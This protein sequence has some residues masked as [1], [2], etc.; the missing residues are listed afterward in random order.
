LP[1]LN[2]YVISVT[3]ACHCILPLNLAFISLAKLE[4]HFMSPSFVFHLML[5]PLGWLYFVIVYFVVLYYYLRSY[6]YPLIE[7]LRPLSS[8]FDVIFPLKCSSYLLQHLSHSFECCCCHSKFL[9]ATG[10]FHQPHHPL[11]GPNIYCCKLLP[12]RLKVC[13]MYLSGRQ[14]PISAL[15]SG[16][17]HISFDSFDYFVTISRSHAAHC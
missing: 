4:T 2:Q 8:F 15:D 12:Q 10:S 13:Y 16:G 14:G 3:V 11:H 1:N 7:A 17:G 9:R 6:Y 5:G